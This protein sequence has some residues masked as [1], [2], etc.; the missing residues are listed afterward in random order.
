MTETTV[1]AFNE[2]IPLDEWANKF[3]LDEDLARKGKNIKILF[4]GVSNVNPYKLI[5]IVKAE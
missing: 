1:F 5:V 4:R 2:N 3:D